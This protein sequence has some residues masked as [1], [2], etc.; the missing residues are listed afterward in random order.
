MNKCKNPNCNKKIP[1]PLLPFGGWYG[2]CSIICSNEYHAIYATAEET[3]QD[4]E[5]ARIYQE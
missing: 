2:C 3:Q 1:K 5:R 4:I